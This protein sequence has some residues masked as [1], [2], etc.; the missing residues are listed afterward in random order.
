[1]PI[2]VTPDETV[3]E[4]DGPVDVCVELANSVESSF[5]IPFTITDGSAEGKLCLSLLS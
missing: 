5:N 1:M 2:I 4:G 3:S